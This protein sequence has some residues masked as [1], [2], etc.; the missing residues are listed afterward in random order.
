MD[1]FPGQVGMVRFPSPPHPVVG[2]GGREK[3]KDWLSESSV[4]PCQVFHFTVLCSIVVADWHE[5]TWIDKT[6]MSCM[7]SLSKV[8]KPK[9]FWAFDEIIWISQ[10]LFTDVSR[11]IETCR[12]WNSKLIE[13]LI[14]Q[15]PQFVNQSISVV[16][17][18]LWSFW[19]FCG[20]SPK[21]SNYGS[22]KVI[23]TLCKI[24]SC[25]L[26]FEPK[27]SELR[28]TTSFQ[29]SD[30]LNSKV[31]LLL[32]ASSFFFYIGGSNDG[33][34]SDISSGI[35]TLVVPTC[36]SASIC[37][38]VDL[39]WIGF[40]VKLEW[41]GF[42]L[43]PFFKPDLC[44]LRRLCS[45]RLVPAIPLLGAGMR[46][47]WWSGPPTWRQLAHLLNLEGS[48]AG[49]LLLG[50]LSIHQNDGRWTSIE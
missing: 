47:L 3:Q 23:S 37:L 29:Q 18:S 24:P 36:W 20:M 31:Q 35:C 5:V 49:L 4:I 42:H 50:T 38:E 21:L 6:Q 27:T 17:M 15:H 43:P 10:T 40:Q 48:S 25:H 44:R 11:F 13:F 1:R 2:S 8:F 28:M 22:K 45:L 12:R 41:F 7:P 33:W 32:A 30:W 39:E 34:D 14:V 26:S 16:Y 19:S 9:V 46:T